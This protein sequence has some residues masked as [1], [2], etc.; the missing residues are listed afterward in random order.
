MPKTT[1]SRICRPPLVPERVRAIRGQGFAFIPNRFLLEGF[2][3]ELSH[4]E[5]LLYLLLVLA[6]DRSGMSGFRL[7]IS[8]VALDELAVHFAGPTSNSGAKQRSIIQSRLKFL[9]YLFGG[10]P[11]LAPTHAA[12]VDKL[13]GHMVG[14]PNLRYWLSGRTLLRERRSLMRLRLVSTVWKTTCG[15]PDKISSSF[16]GQS[17]RWENR[18][19]KTSDLPPAFAR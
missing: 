5:M 2:F 11:P 19:K 12:L 14:I 15:A 7:N 13:G 9:S 18:L 8:G 6:S 10:V 4:D 17:R 16:P 1:T 3:A